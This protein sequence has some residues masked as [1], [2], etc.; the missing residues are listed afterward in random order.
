MFTVQ[1]NHSTFQHTTDF[2][3]FLNTQLYNKIIVFLNVNC[4]IKSEYF[5]T[6][7]SKYWELKVLGTHQIWSLCFVICAI[8]SKYFW[9]FT[10]QCNHSIFEQYNDTPSVPKWLW[11]Y[12]CA[13]FFKMVEVSVVI[14]WIIDH[15]I[16]YRAST[17]PQSFWNGGSKIKT[18]IKQYYDFNPIPF[19]LFCILILSG[20]KF[21]RPWNLCTKLTKSVF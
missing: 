4:T 17:I 8:Q 14:L 3:V 12:H 13:I 16:F 1:Y 18:R 9:M 11:D 10:V 20:G 6:L 5:W 15:F 2:S 21:D 19:G 7:Q